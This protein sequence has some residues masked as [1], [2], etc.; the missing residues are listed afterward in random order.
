MRAIVA[1]ALVTGA[2]SFANAHKGESHK[3]DKKVDRPGVEEKQDKDS[4]AS[5][6]ESYLSVVKPIFKKSCFDCHSSDTKFPWYSDLPR[7]KQLIQSDIA[8]AK[9][10]LDMSEDFPFKG[11]GSPREDLEAIDK[12]VIDGSMPPFRYRILHPASKLTDSE[13]KAIREWV[14][15]SL[16]ILEEPT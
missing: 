5:I 3:G 12:A 4:L 16:K 9:E 8:E 15:K 2:M 14:S 11:H 6:N 7:A 13:K 10:H 1:I